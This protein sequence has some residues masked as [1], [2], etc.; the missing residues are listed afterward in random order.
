MQ[1]ASQDQWPGIR[2][3]KCRRYPSQN[4]SDVTFSKS[5]AIIP[6]PVWACNVE[7][8]PTIQAADNS[9]RV[10][11]NACSSQQSTSLCILSFL[12]LCTLGSMA[13]SDWAARRIF[14][15]IGQG[16]IGQHST[17]TE[18]KRKREWEKAEREEY[19]SLR[20]DES[21]RWRWTRRWRAGWVSIKRQI[22]TKINPYKKKLK[23]GHDT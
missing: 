13:W 15:S 22:L 7:S 8:L 19:H 4:N 21:S 16:P 10:Q 14:Y 1:T 20:D 17:L 12:A 18:T 3:K 5:T 6:T 9:I 23:K 2:Q 11:K